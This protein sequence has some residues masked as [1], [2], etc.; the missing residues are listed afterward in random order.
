[1]AL[2]NLLPT[3]TSSIAHELILPEGGIQFG[4]LCLADEES[5]VVNYNRSKL[6]NILYVKALERRLTGAGYNQVYVNAVHPGYVSTEV[7][8]NVESTVGYVA[9]KVLNKTRELIGRT[10]A[11]GAVSQLYCATSPQIEEKNLSGRYF[12]PDAH[13][14]TPGSFALNVEL[15]ERLYKY[16]EDFMAKRGLLAYS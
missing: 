2:P 3:P 14:I 8:E 9:S 5:P 4:T 13:E 7:D 6:A 1:M 12:V 11:E 10:A 16:S 15:Q